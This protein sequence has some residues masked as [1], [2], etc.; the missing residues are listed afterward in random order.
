MNSRNKSTVLLAGLACGAFVGLGLPD[1][2]LGVAWPSIRNDFNLPID[3][4]GFLLV[5]FTSGYLVSSFSSGPLLA[6]MS[7][8]T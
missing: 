8:G 5:V 1:G 4:L 7:I 2:L 3:A 6:R